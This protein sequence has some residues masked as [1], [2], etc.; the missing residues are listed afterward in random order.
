[1]NQ[2]LQ[3][4]IALQVELLYATLLS[5][6]TPND[7][8]AFQAKHC[9][10]YSDDSFFNITLLAIWDEQQ[11]AMVHISTYLIRIPIY[12][13]NSFSFF[14][15]LMVVKAVANLHIFWGS[16]LTFSHN[17][18]TSPPSPIC[19][20]V[21]VLRGSI[22]GLRQV[23]RPCAVSTKIFT[24]T[25]PRPLILFRVLRILAGEEPEL[26]IRLLRSPSILGSAALQSDIQS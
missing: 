5:K 4:Q 18:S 12:F 23:Q 1:V 19:S 8:T 11:V 7:L 3:S 10:L 22:N 13:A 9:I 26:E 17:L 21:F 14:S 15:N 16:L 25:S 6:K 2:P 20:A 24:P